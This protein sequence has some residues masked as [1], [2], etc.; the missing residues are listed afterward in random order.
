M[1]KQLLI[2]VSGAPGT[3][4]TWLAREVSKRFQIPLLHRD[5]V[6]EVLYDHLGWSDREWSK[7]LGI[8]SYRLIEY[9][10]R[11]QLSSGMSYLVESNFSPEFD[12]AWLQELQTT[13]QLTII[14]IYCSCKPE[15]AIERFIARVESGERHPGH[16]DQMSRGELETHIRSWGEKNTPLPLEGTLIHLDTSNFATARYQ[17]VYTGIQNHLT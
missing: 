13:H 10:L 17:D 1:S 12:T 9:L 16:V 11:L 14:Q 8:A 2:L 6:K 7:K 5:G 15:I 4:K 3:G